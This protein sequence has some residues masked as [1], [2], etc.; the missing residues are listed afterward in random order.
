MFGYSDKMIFE[1]K[2]ACSKYTSFHP[3]N[4]KLTLT[5]IAVTAKISAPPLHSLNM[6]LMKNN[7]ASGMVGNI[8]S[9]SHPQ[10]QH[11]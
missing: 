11:R 1:V 6:K 9:V 3:I 10:W 4:P 5:E 2:K 8:K 7:D